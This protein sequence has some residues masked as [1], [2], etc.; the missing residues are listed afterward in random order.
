MAVRLALRQPAAALLAVLGLPLAC[1]LALGLAGAQPARAADST[2][3]P[4]ASGQHV[5]DYGHVLSAHSAQ[6]AEKLA[7]SIE[8]AGGGRVVIYTANEYW[9]MPA[10]NDLVAAWQVDGMLLTGSAD[11]SGQLTLGD[12]LKA[13]LAGGVKAIDTSSGMHTGESWILSS[14]ARADGILAR[15]HVF[16]GAGALDDAGLDQAEKSATDLG[17]SLGVPVYVDISLGGDDPSTAAFF[18]GAHLDGVFGKSMVIALSVSGTQIGGYLTYTSDIFDKYSTGDPWAYT[19]I[20]NA[21]A[22][23]G[24]V[25]AALLAAIEGVHGKSGI[26]NFLNGDPGGIVVTLG[27]IALCFVLALAFGPFIVRKLAGVSG[28][29]KG[30]LPTTATITSVGETGV[31]VTMPSVGPEAPDYELGLD[32]IPPGG[33]T[34]YH[35]DTRAIVPRVFVPIIVPGRQLAVQVDPGNP[36]HVVPDWQRTGS[37]EASAGATGGGPVQVAGDMTGALAFGQMGGTMSV[38]GV[39]VA[40]DKSGKPTSGLDSVVGAIRGGTM[41][42]EHGSAAQ[43]LATGTHGTAVV[44]TAQP[45]GKKVRDIDPKADPSRLDDPIWLFTVE[46]TL[47]GRSAYP[48][49]FGH[50]VPA[51]R[52][53]DIGPGTKLSVAVDES[54]P[55]QEV[56]IDWD[57]SPLS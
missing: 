17:K 2:I 30:G 44:T 8:A 19:T 12:T 4:F 32:V 50:R 48:A 36:Q 25:Q 20:E 31:T 5:Y 54:N 45:L 6:V 41:H 42:T 47:P 14:L 56:A 26:E 33:G 23:G 11:V 21:A 51:A 16:D 43:L 18:N 55:T 29:I 46:V 35:V 34:R 49:M 9:D 37:G 28:P 40:F 1:A 53:G 10:T 52:V 3:P 24:D 7:T 22:R 27:F 38:D 39:D 15:K 57:R 13:R